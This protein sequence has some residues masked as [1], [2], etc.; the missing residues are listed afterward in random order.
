MREKCLRPDCNYGR[1]P[2]YIWGGYCSE[3]CVVRH[4]LDISRAEVRM[5]KRA[6]EAHQEA[7]SNR[8]DYANKTYDTAL[9]SVLG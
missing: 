9:W 6:I 5:L 1:E 2:V 3:D 4:E 8:R 7:L